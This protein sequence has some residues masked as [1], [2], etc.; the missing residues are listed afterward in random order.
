[1][2]FYCCNRIYD[3]GDLQKE[4]FA[5]T[6]KFRWLRVSDG[7][8][9]EQL[10]AHILNYKEKAERALWEWGNTFDPPRP[11][12]RALSKHTPNGDQMVR[13]MS[14]WGRFFFKLPYSIPR[15]P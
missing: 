14:L 12:L 13:Y 1:M 10:S 6:H 2:P 11:H 3:R 7:R 5:L 9:Q 15:L 8:V 4:G